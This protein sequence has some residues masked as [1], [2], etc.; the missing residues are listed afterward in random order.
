MERSFIKKGGIVCSCVFHEGRFEFDFAETE[1]EVGKFTGSKYVKSNPQGIYK[2]ISEK[3]KEGEM[4][5]LSDF[6]VRWQR[7]SIIPKIMKICIRLI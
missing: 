1:N 6:R 3:L 4:Y 7:Q 2:K 5:F